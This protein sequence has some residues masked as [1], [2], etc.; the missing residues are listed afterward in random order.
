MRMRS[1]GLELCSHPA[2]L[3]PVAP[4]ERRHEHARRFV[5]GA[6][7]LTPYG[8]LKRRII[9]ANYLIVGKR[10]KQ[11]S[12]FRPPKGADPEP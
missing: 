11:S 2:S 3:K 12:P 7:P 4:L 6:S 1:R 5:S 8:Y 9:C 10:Q